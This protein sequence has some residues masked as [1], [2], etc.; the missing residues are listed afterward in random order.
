MNRHIMSKAAAIP[1]L[2]HIH[3]FLPALTIKNI[4]LYIIYILVKII[5]G[6]YI[7]VFIKLIVISIFCLVSN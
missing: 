7:F 1:E 5:N 2:I 6:N 4:F 3:L